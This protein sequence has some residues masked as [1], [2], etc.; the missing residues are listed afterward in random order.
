MN[1]KPF[2]KDWVGANVKWKMSIQ[3]D[4]ISELFPTCEAKKADAKVGDFEWQLQCLEGWRIDQVERLHRNVEPF[5]SSKKRYL[6]EMIKAL[7]E[8]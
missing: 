4:L 5:Y 3:L 6:E 8:F 2:R 7:R 1:A